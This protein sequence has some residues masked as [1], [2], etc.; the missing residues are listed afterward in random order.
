MFTLQLQDDYVLKMLEKCYADDLFEVTDRNREYLRQWLP[1]VDATQSVKQ[2]IEFIYAMR[3]AYADY[4]G[5]TLGIFHQG[6]IVGCVGLNQ[7]DWR[8]KRTDI[9]Y[10]LAKDHMGHGVMTAACKVLID[11]AFV[12]L[13]LNRVEIRAATENSK[14]RAIPERLEFVEEGVIRQA[15]WLYDHYVDHV[16]Y[17]MLKEEWYERDRSM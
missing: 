15:E 8:N 10:W 4:K 9:G 6:H 1:W 13:K 3:Q 11:Y 12:E 7:I 16:V 14:S 2:S 17:S 5:F